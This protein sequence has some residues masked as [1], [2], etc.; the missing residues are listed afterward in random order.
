MLYFG[1]IDELIRVCIRKLLTFTER[2]E[3]IANLAERLLAADRR[4][5]DLKE[6]LHNL[7][8]AE[9]E[10]ELALQ[11]QKRANEDLKQELKDQ[12]ELIGKLKVVYL[13]FKTL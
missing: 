4:E 2:K 3:E 6:K 13:S 1:L 12:D 5:L 11:E 8:K 10:M 7:Q 9:K